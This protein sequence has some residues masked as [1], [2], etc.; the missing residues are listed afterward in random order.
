MLNQFWNFLAA[1]KPTLILAFGWFIREIPV[2][3]RGLQTNGGVKGFWRVILN[4]QTPEKQEAVAAAAA[5]AISPKTETQPP[6]T[7][8]KINP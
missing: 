3:Y 2:V 5:V 1:H 6:E 8:N 7:A 4:G